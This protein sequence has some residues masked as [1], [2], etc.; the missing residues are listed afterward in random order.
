[1]NDAPL[2]I[3]LVGAGGI[4]RTAHVP[5]W[6]DTKGCEIVAV[7]DRDRGAA[8][9]MAASLGITRVH[10]E[11]DDL[12]KQPDIHIIDIC[13]PNCSHAPAALAGLAAG[14]HVLCEKP[15]AVTAA[16]V[17]AIAQA[18]QRAGRL[19]CSVQ[20]LRWTPRPQALKRWVDSGE[21]GEV[22]H[23]RVHA[24]RRDLLPTSPSFIDKSQSGGG[25]CMDIG[26][27]ALDIALWLM[28]SPTPLRVSGSLRVNFAKGSAIRSQ[29]GEWDRERFTVED[30]ASG[31]VHFADGRTLFLESAWMQHQPE[32]EDFSVRLFGS[33]ASVQWP[34]GEWAAF[35]DGAWSGG[36]VPDATGLVDSHTEE[37][38]AFV[39]AIRSG[40]QAPVPLEQTL[41]VIAILEAIGES[42]RLDREVVL[43]HPA[44]AAKPL[45]QRQRS[46]AGP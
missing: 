14:K 22:Y 33:K 17:T 40:A 19:A 3:G 6:R 7:C 15:L 21:L 38:R 16:D 42:A 37:I 27:H 10:G 46:H 32:N 25:A 39:A 4:M 36:V 28:G 9:R 5:A 30:F 31:I 23:A 35:R 2:R 26:V 43:Q 34:S 18:A 29:F 44:L 12:L 20:N 41:V 24:L 8:E 13:T 1:M 11:L 45:E